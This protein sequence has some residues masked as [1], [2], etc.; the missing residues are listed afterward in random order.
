MN[1]HPSLYLASAIFSLQVAEFERDAPDITSLTF[2]LA[3]GC[4]ACLHGG[5]VAIFSWSQ[6]S[7]AVDAAGMRSKTRYAA[8]VISGGFGRMDIKLGMLSPV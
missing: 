1:L 2:D 4:V 5:E 8:A 6:L 3:T 7:G